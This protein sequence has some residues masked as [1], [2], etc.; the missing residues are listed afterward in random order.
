[1]FALPFNP[2]PHSILCTNRDEFLSRPTMAAEFHSF[3]HEAEKASILS[4]RDLRA[5]G[6]WLGMNLSGRVALLY[7]TA[8]Y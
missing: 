8:N 2:R 4:G 7:V 6:T 5:G 3:G 1:M